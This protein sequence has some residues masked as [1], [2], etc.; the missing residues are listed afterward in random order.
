VRILA[1]YSHPFRLNH[2]KGPIAEA[3]MNPSATQKPQGSWAPGICSKF[4]P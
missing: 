4:M 1:V 3:S 2:T